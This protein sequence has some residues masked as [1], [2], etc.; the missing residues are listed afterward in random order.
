MD[1]I[2]ARDR[3][4]LELRYDGPIPAQHLD[5]DQARRRRQQTDENPNESSGARIQQRTRLKTLPHRIPFR[6]AASSEGSTH[7]ITTLGPASYKVSRVFLCRGAQTVTKAILPVNR[8]S[9]CES[10]DWL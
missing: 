7:P 9:T 10:S 2:P 5:T 1:D 8:D 3:Q 6:L 4:D